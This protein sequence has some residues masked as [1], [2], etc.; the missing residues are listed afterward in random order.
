MKRRRQKGFTLVEMLVA[1]GL[2]AA[3]FSAVALLY[4]S[5]TVHQRRLASLVSVELGSTKVNNYFDVSGSSLRVYSAPNYG[6]TAFAEEMRE[7]FWDDVESSSAVFCLSRDQANT[8]RPSTIPFLSANP[9]RIDTPNGFRN[10]LVANF[11]AAGPTFINYRGKPTGTNASIYIIDHID[12]STAD[13]N[14]MPVRAV[15]DIDLDT[16]SGKTGTY[17]S[18]KRYQYGQL[19]NYYDVYFEPESGEPFAPVFVYFERQT[20]RSLG[21]AESIQRLQQGP[22]QPFYMIWWP[23]PGMQFLERDAAVPTYPSSDPRVDYAGMGGRTSFSFVV[24]AY[25]SM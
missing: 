17:A 3:C 13:P 18:V 25:P 11:P 9:P 21:E 14:M 1:G 16:P 6:R 4:Q 12:D 10:L 5:V 24:P 20:R 15:Y 23:D 2:A 7:I 19:T 22:G 8:V